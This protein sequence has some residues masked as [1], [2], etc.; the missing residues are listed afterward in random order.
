MEFS[1]IMQNNGDYTVQDISRITILVPME[2][3]HAT[4]CVS[5]ITSLLPCT[6]SKYGG[7]FVQLLLATGDVH[8]FT[9][10][11]EAVSANTDALTA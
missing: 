10:F 8:L 4:C 7:L 5:I 2:S 11:T 3:L 6:I 9:E 1:K